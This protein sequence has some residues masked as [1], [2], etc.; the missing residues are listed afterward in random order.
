[1]TRITV[2]QVT[3]LIFLVLFLGNSTILRSQS[4]IPTKARSNA[5]QNEWRTSTPEAQGIDSERLA[6]MLDYIAKNGTNIHSLQIVRRG[7]LVMDAYFYPF[8][9]NS[10]HDTASVTKTV[11][12]TLVGIALDKGYLK[13][14]DQKILDILSAHQ[15]F[16]ADS[17]KK[18]ITVE[19]LL[20]MASGLE[21][22]LKRGEPELF[23]MLKTDGSWVQYV[24]N[25][26]MR[27][28]PGNRF[29][30]CS[31]GM[32][33]L[34][35]VLTKVTGR[36]QLDSARENLF[37]P[38]GITDVYWQSDREGITHGWGDLHLKPLD[39]AKIGQ[40]YLNRGRWEGRQ[41]ISEKW[42]EQATRRQIK[43]GGRDDYGY[44][45]WI[46]GA[47]PG[48]FEALGRRGQRIDVLPDKD[49]VIVMT[50]GGF[51]PGNLAPFLLSALKSDQPLPENPTAQRL[52]KEKL[53]AATL[54][55]QRNKAHPLPATAKEISEKI[56]RLDDN[57]L[58]L[59]SFQVR[60][61]NESE[62]EIV[63]SLADRKII[64]PIG[65]DGLYRIGAEGPA[66]LPLGGRAEWRSANELAL[67]LNMIAKINRYDVI[68]RFD[69]ER[70]HLTI[71]ESTGLTNET[72]TGIAKR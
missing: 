44:G 60:F 46:S 23:E 68:A 5:T 63:L 18:S 47:I 55:P 38:L 50:G 48:L 59:R 71:K 8:P 25:L 30:Y 4:S 67:D 37:K 62:G 21:C 45:W 51:E 35:A 17:R 19:N 29:A 52:L 6:A 57:S 54:P 42:I 40:L 14:T 9:K 20:K 10:M 65:L 58:G 3:G 15:S 28:K 39:M 36:S 61:F 26:P 7:Y 1:M 11:T 69:E 13:G 41:I 24:L 16:R 72:I 12:A 66:K 43:T 27:D 70:I 49:L 31:G 2:C 53:Q 32:H 64:F 22:G 33:L 34:S 56:Y